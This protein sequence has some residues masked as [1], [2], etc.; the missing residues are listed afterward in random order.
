MS[1]NVE[2][3]LISKVKKS[4]KYCQQLDETTDITK[5]PQLLV[6]IRYIELNEMKEEMLFCHELQTYTTG[7]EIFKEL[8]NYISK[9]LN[10]EQCIAV[11]TDGAASMTGRKS[12][13]INRIKEINP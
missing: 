5:C 7:E 6:Y 10:R 3:Q 8:N 9:Y 2:N 12:G 1:D 11:C 4:P 13:L